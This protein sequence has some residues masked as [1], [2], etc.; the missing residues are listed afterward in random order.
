M[1]F[2]YRNLM[3]LESNLLGKSRPKVLPRTRFWWMKLESSA[4]PWN[5]H[6]CDVHF[7][8]LLILLVS[9]SALVIARIDARAI[10]SR[11]INTVENPS[12]ANY[13]FSG[14]RLLEIV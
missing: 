2:P 13:S 6:H 14:T 3:I 11:S 1:P 4:T 9:C 12:L 7:N 5:C 10:D 8:F